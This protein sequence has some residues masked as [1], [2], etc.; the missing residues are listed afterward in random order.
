M[1][2][3]SAQLTIKKRQGRNQYS[4]QII[5]E[6]ILPLRMMLIP[7]G[8]F[9]MGSPESEL[10]R[11]DDEGPQHEVKVPQFFMAKYPVT[12]AQWR[13]VA[14]MPKVKQVLKPDPSF[15]KGK[16]RPVEKVSW[17]DAVEF[18]DRLTLHTNRQYRLPSEAEWEYACRAGT[19]TPFHFGKT[20]STDYANYKSVDKRFRAYS[21][22]TQGRYRKETTPVNHF[23]GANAFGLFDM[24]GNVWEWCEDRWHDGYDE[25]PDDAS[26][27]IE[28]GNSSSRI[29][30]G[31]NW[32]AYPE[33]CRSAVCIYD[34]PDM[35]SNT[36]GFRVVCSAPK[37]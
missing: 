2:P 11:Q 14:N 9:L 13:E 5:A 4:D 10:E 36:I 19:T 6:D 1:E 25:A 16:L 30:R 32:S 20:L 8:T 23:E 33:I 24:H 12:Q 17:Y 3:P 35:V 26:A 28:G 15:F 21:P 22:V 29:L 18:C 27:W 37:T 7:A 34:E 31:G